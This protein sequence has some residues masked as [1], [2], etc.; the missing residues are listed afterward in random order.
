MKEKSKVIFSSSLAQPRVISSFFFSASLPSHRERL[1]KTPNVSHCNI[2]RALVA[3]KTT[4]GNCTRIKKGP[5]H[6]FLFWRERETS[7]T[8]TV[9]LRRKVVDHNEVWGRGGVVGAA[10]RMYDRT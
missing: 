5:V 1:L 8:N 7:D 3:K 4:V 10:C 2:H 9:R 6:W